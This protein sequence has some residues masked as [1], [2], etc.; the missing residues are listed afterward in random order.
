MISLKNIIEVYNIH[1]NENIN[2]KI[3]IK[4]GAFK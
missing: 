1:T 3:N 4:D 2:Q